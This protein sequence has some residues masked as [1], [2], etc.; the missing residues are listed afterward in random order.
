MPNFKYKFHMLDI[1][2]IIAIGLAIYIAVKYFTKPVHVSVMESTDDDDSVNKL[3]KNSHSVNVD[4]LTDSST[5]LRAAANNKEHVL[6][7]QADVKDKKNYICNKE[8][9]CDER[10]VGE[11][12]DDIRKQFMSP[13]ESFYGN[14]TKTKGVSLDNAFK[15]G[16]GKEHNCTV[17]P[18]DKHVINNV[19]GDKTNFSQMNKNNKLV[20]DNTSTSM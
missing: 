14:V 16:D 8:C 7:N 13:T 11:S 1:L 9:P 12:L 18:E 3:L 5:K 20:N 17:K 10:T 6:L 4:K 15:L 2:I 19:L